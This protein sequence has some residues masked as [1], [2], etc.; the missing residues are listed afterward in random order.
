M[1]GV[2]G[3]F[4]SKTIWGGIIVL[5]ATV[6]GFLGFNVSADDQTTLIGYL[7][8]AAVIIGGLLAIWGRITATKTIGK[9]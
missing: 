2:K 7:D 3:F 4:G 6:A 9:L 5:V 8:Q 1:D